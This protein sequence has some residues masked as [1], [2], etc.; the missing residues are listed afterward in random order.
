MQAFWRG[1]VHIARLRI[2]VKLYA[3]AEEKAVVLHNRHKECGHA[4]TQLKY[5]AYCA[6]AVEPDELER[7]YQRGGDRPVALTEEE[8]RS[9]A[10]ENDKRFRVVRFARASE[11]PALWM[12][13]HY[14]VG[15]DEVGEDALTLVGEQLRR[16]GCIGIGYI[17]LRSVRQLAG[18]W[19]SDDALV[20]TTLH[21][22]DE[23]RSAPG[24]AQAPSGRP[25]GEASAELGALIEA[26]SGPFEPKQ[27]ANVYQDALRKLV[28]S[29]LSNRPPEDERPPE[30][31][32]ED[33]DSRDLL[34]AIRASLKELGRS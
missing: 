26:M 24:S 12:K 11:V 1:T 10:P 29:K 3:A 20:L 25:D 14:Y 30:P 13:K 2:P 5:C 27:Y 28:A 21:Y 6:M 7:A 22:A 31:A 17:T 34:D 32:D 16:L 33:G 9:I 15:A 8:L 23:V 19:A 18:L 4:V